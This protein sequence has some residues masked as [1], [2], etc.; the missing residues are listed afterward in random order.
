MRVYKLTNGLGIAGG[1]AWGPEVLHR[2][3]GAGRDLAIYAYS[4]VADALAYGPAHWTYDDATLWCATTTSWRLA[5]PLVDCDDLTTHHPH[6]G[7][8]ELGPAEHVSLAVECASEMIG[9]RSFGEWA[10]RWIDGTDRDVRRCQTLLRELEDE[11][12]R[13]DC[14]R[15]QVWDAAMMTVSAAIRLCP[16]VDERAATRAAAT[17]LVMQA[18]H[19]GSRID[20]SNRI[21]RIRGEACEG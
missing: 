9:G 18:W 19:L 13:D 8:R 4:T 21:A 5:G 1:L 10:A 20:L 15:A 7:F 6:P 11:H 2:A 17:S 12:P 16:P 3:A 14:R